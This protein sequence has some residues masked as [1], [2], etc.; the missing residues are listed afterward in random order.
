MFGVPS[1]TRV[2][3]RPD[4]P[5]KRRAWTDI[6]EAVRKQNEL[7][8]KDARLVRQEVTNFE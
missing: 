2:E 5:S 3:F 4:A 7:R 1:Y 8:T 6:E